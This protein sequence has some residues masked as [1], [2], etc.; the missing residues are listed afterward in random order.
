M[1]SETS[2]CTFLNGFVGFTYFG[3]YFRYL[4]SVSDLVYALLSLQ[5]S[6]G[7]F[8]F[9]WVAVLTKIKGTGWLV[10]CVISVQNKH[11]S[12]N[13]LKSPYCLPPT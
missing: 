5:G 1:P 12:G 6:A 9:Q 8:N 10:S 3:F 2:I 13:N 11:R 7:S 4:K